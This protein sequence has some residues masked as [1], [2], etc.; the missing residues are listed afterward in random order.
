MEPA[1]EQVLQVVLRDYDM[2]YDEMIRGSRARAPAE[3][4]HMAFWLVTELLPE[5]ER[6]ACWALRREQTV[7]RRGLVRIRR[8]MQ[9]QPSLGRRA[10][11]LLAAA[12][13]AVQ[14][15]AASNG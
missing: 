13:A 4:R 12:S 1:V 8:D 14:P 6:N 9:A 5:L 10:A 15:K 2:E 3:A 11:T 7:L